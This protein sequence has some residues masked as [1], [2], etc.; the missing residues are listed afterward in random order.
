M[1]ANLPYMPMFWDDWLY[2]PK[3]A[4]LSAES[5]RCYFRLVGVLWK[6]PDCGLPKDDSCYHRL[7][8]VDREEWLRA[9][10][11][12]S[13]F[14]VEHP[15][16][17]AKVTVRRTFFEFQ[18][19]SKKCAAKSKAGAIGRAKQIESARATAGQPPDS[20]QRVPGHR[21][22]EGEGE[23]DVEGD[24]Q[25]ELQLPLAQSPIRARAPEAVSA[26]GFPVV[27]LNNP[28]WFL[29]ER[30]LVEY[31]KSFPALDVEGE[32]RKARAW[33]VSNPGK[34]KTPRGMPKF[35]GGWLERAQNYAGRNGANGASNHRS[36]GHVPHVDDMAKFQSDPTGGW[37]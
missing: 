7:L 28:E 17:P 29:P 36:N 24:L 30:L 33:C 23:G 31:R 16:D 37:K 12:V 15:L 21:E 3:V 4:V 5:E 6:Q 9:R 10:D 35:I 2:D 14:L 20:R 18:E 8:G 13:Q 19:A 22:G 11:Q 27:G 1:S 32:F 25:E 26:F 34:C